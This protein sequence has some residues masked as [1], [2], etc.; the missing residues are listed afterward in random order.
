[1]ASKEVLLVPVVEGVGFLPVLYHFLPSS[2][3]LFSPFV[4]V[5]VRVFACMKGERRAP[6]LYLVN[7][8][9]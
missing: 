3:P 5:C 9:F 6:S 8:G 7:I 2:A 4:H 1:M